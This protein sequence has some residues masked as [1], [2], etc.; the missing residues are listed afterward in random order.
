MRDHSSATK[1]LRLLTVCAAAL[2]HFACSDP[3]PDP[4]STLSEIVA[5]PEAGAS[6]K[7]VS[8]RTEPTET[9]SHSAVIEATM[10]TEVYQFSVF[11]KEGVWY[12]DG[13]ISLV[14]EGVPIT[15]YDISTEVSIAAYKFNFK[16]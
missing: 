16:R 13:P 9:P 5:S 14:S 8:V 11:C 10:G 3:K 2:L 15:A 12:Y 7:V 1:I 6:G 4:K